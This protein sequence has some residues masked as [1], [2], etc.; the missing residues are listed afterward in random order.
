MSTSPPFA[1]P[2]AALLPLVAA[3]DHGAMHELLSRFTPLVRSIARRFGAGAGSADDLVQETMLRLWRSADRFD[4]AR[5]S[6]KTF[7]ASVARNAA[8]DMVRRQ[9]S[10]PATAVAEPESVAASAS[11]AGIGSGSAGG[12]D[13]LAERV[14][15]SL[16]VRSALAELPAAQRELL[17][18]A[19]YDQLTQPEIAERLGIPVGTVKS[20]TFQAMAKL[21]AVLHED[22]D[23]PADEQSAP[24]RTA[25]RRLPERR[26]GPRRPAR[27][28]DRLAR[29]LALAA[30]A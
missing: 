21:R 1:T 26:R 19:Y 12:P 27:S 28:A 2:P 14:V 3:G 20:R 10:R 11:A 13:Q 15:T 22:P 6:E 30:A 9:A 4:P 18:L 23:L 17:R 16:S 8:I 5:G 24:P 7:V 25:C 29:D